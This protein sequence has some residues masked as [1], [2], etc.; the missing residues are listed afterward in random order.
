MKIFV[1]AMALVIA[2]PA[3]AQTAPA[4]AQQDH[5]QHQGHGQ[6]QAGQHGQ[7]QAGQHGQHG[8]GQHGQHQGHDMASGC[9]ADRD[10]NGVM[11]CCENR[12]QGQGHDCCAERGEQPAQAQP[13]AQP[14]R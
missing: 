8:A 9:C 1:T 10:G 5:Q 3:A 11:D 12:A 14:N 4:T 13:G 6:A 7:H 2:M